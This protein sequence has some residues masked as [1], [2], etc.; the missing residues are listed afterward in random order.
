MRTLVFLHAHPD[1]EALLTAGTMARA[2]AEGHRVVLVVATAGEAGLTDAAL[3][4]DGD[5]GERRR[6]ELAESA[7][8]LG[9]A[10]TEVLGYADSGLHGEVPHG[11]ATR[12][13]QAVAD[14]LR[15][16]LADETVDVLVGYDP[17]GGYGHPDHL[18]VHRVAR[19]L[20]Q[21]LGPTARLFE[22]T[23]PRE[24]IARAAHLAKRTGLTPPEFDPHEFDQAWTPRREITHRVDVRAHLD[25][26]RAAL[27]AHASQATADGTTRT[28][29]VLTRLPGPLASTLLGREYYVAV[30][31]PPVTP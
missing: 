28:L 15:E 14:T 8:I 17:S 26:K 16:L 5:L 31:P 20:A 23:L 6:G 30:T 25:A 21:R 22:A 9:V 3:A 4:G 27:A 13:P 7:E 29:A 18:Q 11:F 2:A 12:D 1:D 19:L 24:P 10:R